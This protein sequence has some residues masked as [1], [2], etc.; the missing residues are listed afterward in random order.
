[1][2]KD[3]Y[4]GSSERSRGEIVA[5][6]SSALPPRELLPLQLKVNIPLL[7]VEKIHHFT[8]NKE[9][10]RLNS[11]G[12]PERNTRGSPSPTKP[13]PGLRNTSN[14][15]FLNATIQCLGAIDEINESRT[16]TKKPMTTQDR[17]VLC[18]RELQKTETAYTPFPLIQHIPSLIR[19]K[20]GEPAD[21]HDFLIALINDVIEPISQLFQGQMSSTV[22]YSLCKRFTISTDNTHDISISPFGS[23]RRRTRHLKT[24]CM[25]SFNVR[26]WKGKT[27]TSATPAKRLVE[28]QEPSS[29]HEPLRS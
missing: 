8:P 27:H 9:E 26:Y 19:Y 13:G 12:K 21:A 20:K 2:Q 22:K 23:M 17:L 10:R 25:T 24:A 18:I 6:N 7:Q 16:S 15:C 4:D 29:T 3:T 11:S 5:A 28:R 14:T 1:M